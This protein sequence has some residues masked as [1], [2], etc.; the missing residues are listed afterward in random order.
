MGHHLEVW[1]SVNVD[2]SCQEEEVEMKGKGR[3]L[4]EGFLKVIGWNAGQSKNDSSHR[5]QT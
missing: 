2:V 1:M 5:N 3:E 4:R